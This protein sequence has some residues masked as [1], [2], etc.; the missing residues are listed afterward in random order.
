MNRFWKAVILT[1]LFVGT[2]DLFCAYMSQWIKTGKYADKM[3]LYIAGGT[4]GL[5]T[6][7]QGDNWVALLGLCTHYFIAFTFTVFFFWVF[8][9][10][11]FLSFNKYVIGVLYGIFANLVVGQIIRWFTPLPSQPFN[12]STVL[13]AWFILGIALGIP[14]A[15]NTY[16]YYG[17]KGKT[18]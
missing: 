7:M 10:L 3:L 4:L 2:A 5:D 18:I 16:K 9:K 14:I 12:L 13:V 17:V 8:P 15:C 6:S 11:K 1:W